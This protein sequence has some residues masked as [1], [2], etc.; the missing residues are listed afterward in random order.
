MLV[1]GMQRIDVCASYVASRLK[2][3]PAPRKTTAT[4][5][6]DEQ[7]RRQAGPAAVPVGEWMNK[8]QPV[9]EAGREFIGPIALMHDPIAR[10]A[11]NQPKLG[12]DAKR[13]N[14]DILL[15]CAVFARPIPN[16]IEHPAVKAA[17]EAF[18]ENFPFSLEDPLIRFS[19]VLLFQF[20]E[21]TP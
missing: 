10:I 5:L 17:K 11:Y 13:L 15:R 6:Y 12:L 4:L 9:M 3:G 2:I 8:N 1:C 7:V 20:V 21:F 16:V 14:A 18:V 19:D